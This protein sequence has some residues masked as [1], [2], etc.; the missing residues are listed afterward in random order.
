MT[1]L[2]IL[3]V[4]ANKVNAFADFLDE[5]IHS[6]LVLLGEPNPGKDSKP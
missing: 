6:L 4:Q 2:T 1:V 3:P 5:P